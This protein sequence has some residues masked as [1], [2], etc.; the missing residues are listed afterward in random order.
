[1]KC[2]QDS[3]A[4]L[5]GAMAHNGGHS[6]L[7]EAKHY[8]DEVLPAMASVRQYADALEGMVADDLWALPTYQEMLF[9]K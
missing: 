1:V 3:T 2:L 5:E 4:D 9:I 6:L 7:A 8:R